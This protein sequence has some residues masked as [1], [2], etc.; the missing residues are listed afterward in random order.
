MFE[1]D[2]L[3]DGWNL[4]LNQMDAV[5]VPTAFHA[6]VFKAGGVDE[7]KLRILGE[8]V[9]TVFFDPARVR[10]LK[11]PGVGRSTF[12]LVSVFKWEERKAWDVLLQSYFSEFSADEDVVLVILTNAYH[13]S[14][15]FEAQMGRWITEQGLGDK[16]LP[17]VHFHPKVPQ[18][19]L[20]GFYKAGDVFVLPSRGEGWG[21]PHVEAMAMGLP[22]IATNWS[23]PT[24]Y[25]TESNSFP[26]RIDGLTEVREGAFKGHLW[27]QPSVEHLRERMRQVQQDRDAAK[28]R[29]RHARRDMM[30][31]YSPSVLGAQALRLIEEVQNTTVFKRTPSTQEL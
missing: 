25:M 4:R 10:A 21:R 20:P 16:A 13:S 24:E 26:L 14:D 9:D 5:W 28:D 11:F 2:R 31:K 18:T 23:G 3:P 7:S 15:D 30:E 27:A 17:R 8:P 1:T 22:I 19:S 12:V 29:G 6:S